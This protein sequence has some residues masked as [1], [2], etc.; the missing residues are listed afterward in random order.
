MPDASDSYR[1]LDLTVLN[2]MI[3]EEQLGITPENEE[4]RVDYTMSLDEGRKL[5]ENGEYT[6]MFVI[7]PV[8][9][10]QFNAMTQTGER[11]PK[12][13]VSIFP[14]PATGIVIHKFTNDME[15]N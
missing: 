7:N 15:N 5:V 11:L 1:Q 2:K 3:L 14:K 10:P 13:S 4:D 8:R 6:C 12:R 9:P